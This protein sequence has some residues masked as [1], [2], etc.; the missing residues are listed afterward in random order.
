MSPK[1]L[2]HPVIELRFDIESSEADLFEGFPAVIR[3]IVIDKPET[4]EWRL[5][6]EL[7]RHL[8][9]PVF[10]QL[11]DLRN[12]YYSKPGEH[13]QDD[14]LLEWINERMNEFP[15][16]IDPPAKLIG[17][18][19]SAWEKENAEEIL[20]ICQLLKDSLIRIV[21]QEERVHFAIFP[22][23]LERLHNL[24]KNTLGAQADHFSEIPDALDGVVALVGGN[25]GGTE[26]NPTI[27]EKTIEFELPDNW[28][29]DADS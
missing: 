17:Q 13:V 3:R 16:L 24:L 21:E 27:V 11:N 5:T 1:S 20:H 8:N 7:M 15:I 2:G 4:W 12:G 18:L 6:A 9:K 23:E 10:R 25:H 19:N 26:E 28:V 14:Y 22:E 29:D